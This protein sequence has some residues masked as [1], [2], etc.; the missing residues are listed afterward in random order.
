M[1]HMAITR[2][3]AL[4][5][6]FRIRFIDLIQTQVLS[7]SLL[8]ALCIQMVRTL[9]H[10]LC[11]RRLTTR[12]EGFTFSPDGKHAY[13]TDTGISY[14]FYGYNLTDPSSMYVSQIFV[15]SNEAL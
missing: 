2:T 11:S 15:L 14:G 3:S 12:V 8:M 13:V 10:W 6:A 5:L 7:E 4:R 9:L 1:F